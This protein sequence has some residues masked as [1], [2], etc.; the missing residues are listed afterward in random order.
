MSRW[1]T[2]SLLPD[3][4]NSDLGEREEYLWK[5]DYICT[6]MYLLFPFPFLC[7]WSDRID[8]QRR[9]GKQILIDHPLCVGR[10][11]ELDEYIL[12]TT[13]QKRIKEKT[14]EKKRAH[15]HQRRG[16][17]SLGFFP[18]LLCWLGVLRRG[19]DL[20]KKRVRGKRYHTCYKKK[21]MP[22]KTK[23]DGI[24]FQLQNVCVC[25][26]VKGSERDH[27]KEKFGGL[28]DVRFSNTLAH[29][30]VKPSPPF[31]CPK[32]FDLASLCHHLSVPHLTY[33]TL[34]TIY[35]HTET[36]SSR[37]HFH[38]GHQI[39]PGPPLATTTTSFSHRSA[40]Y[41]HHSPWQLQQ[42]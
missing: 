11:I 35:R 6:S 25:S 41:S 27:I 15:W 33:I 8:S 3:V 21:K 22:Y 31:A 10:D 19:R 4:L 42:W 18:N 7:V 9:E 32:P 5:G 40:T 34:H 12:Y 29:S 24:A 13:I 30:Q 37:L 1:Q 28:N 17:G 14:K 36:L 26:C 23:A 38:K 2:V 16:M 39:F 20:I